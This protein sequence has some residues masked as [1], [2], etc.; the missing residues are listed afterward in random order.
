MAPK[1]QAPAAPTIKDITLVIDNGGFTMKAGIVVSEP[2]AEQCSV[3][4]NCIA[5]DREK[6]VFVG[7]QLEKAK[8]FGEMVFRRPIEKGYVVNW[9]GEKA[10]WN[11]SFLAQSA[12]LKVSSA[13]LLRRPR[14]I[15]NLSSAIQK[16]RT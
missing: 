5:R 3:I 8:D 6:H 11:Q 2:D 15:L 14:R 7:P 4:P 12:P 9:E 10:I 13:V 1:K 16:S